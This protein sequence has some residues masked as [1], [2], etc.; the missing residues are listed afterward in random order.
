MLAADA[1]GEQLDLWCWRGLLARLDC[2]KG[3]TGEVRLWVLE[4]AGCSCTW[5]EVG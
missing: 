3:V 2:V 5:R 1:L 4:A